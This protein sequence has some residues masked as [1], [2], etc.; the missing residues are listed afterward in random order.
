MDW[1]ILLVA[2]A[3]GS[4]LFFNDVNFLEASNF[5]ITNNSF[6][7]YAIYITSVTIADVPLSYVFCEIEYYSSEDNFL[8]LSNINSDDM[9]GELN[10]TLY[11]LNFYDFDISGS[12]KLV[13]PYF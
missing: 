5:V 12:G 10:I 3:G 1:V 8:S 7:A 2:T 11:A 9:D 13:L 6:G 4:L